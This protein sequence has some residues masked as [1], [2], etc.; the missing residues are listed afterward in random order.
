ME[1]IVNEENDWHQM[2]NVDVVLGTIQRITGVEIIN[3]V[4]KMK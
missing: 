4:K 3:A 1:K 2:T